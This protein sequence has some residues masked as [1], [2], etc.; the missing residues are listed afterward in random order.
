MDV[1]FE[2]SGAIRS[3][4][5]KPNADSTLALMNGSDI[6]AQLVMPQPAT[7]DHSMLEEVPAPAR[8]LSLEPLGCPQGPVWAN[9]LRAAHR[10]LRHPD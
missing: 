4:L 5:T 3:S 8:D 7:W 9:K 1:E 2:M 10:L 6:R